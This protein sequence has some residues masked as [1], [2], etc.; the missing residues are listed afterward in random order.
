MNT[1]MAKMSEV[2]QLVIRESVQVPN[3]FFD[4]IMP[5]ARPADFKILLFIWRKTVGWNKRKDFISITQIRRGARVCRE[6][7]ISAPRFWEAVGLIRRTGRS[8]IRGTTQYEI[9][10]NYDREGVVSRLKQLVYGTDQSAR[11]ASIFPS[12][13]WN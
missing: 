2:R 5:V 10:L 11:P 12:K 1:E 13:T 3:F 6:K 7:A 4:A 8:G 9:V